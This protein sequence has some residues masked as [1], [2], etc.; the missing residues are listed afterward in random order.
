M[1]FP[2]PPQVPFK[3][4]QMPSAK[5]ASVGYTDENCPESPPGWESEGQGRGD[6]GLGA[7]GKVQP[8]PRQSIASMYLSST[9]TPKVCKTIAF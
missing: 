9:W 4:P 6:D 2:A 3:T 1:G 8:M 7:L 5:E